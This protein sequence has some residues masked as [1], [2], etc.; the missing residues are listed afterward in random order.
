MKKLLAILTF[1]GCALLLQAQ[2]VKPFIKAGQEFFETG[3]YNE[4]VDQF[5]KAIDLQP[6][7]ADH[8]V[9]RARAYERLD[10]KLK[11]AEDYD[12]AITFDVKEED[13]YNSAAKLYFQLQEYPKT[14]ERCKASLDLSMDYEILAIKVDALLKNKNYSEALLDAKLL[15]LKKS[16]D[17]NNYR[18]GIASEAS[19]FDVDA[20]KAYQSAIDKNKRFYEAYTSLANLQ[21]KTKNSI[22]ALANV[23]EA[24]KINPKYAEAYR[25]R[26]QIY[27]EQLKMAEVINDISTVILLEPEVDENYFQRGLYYQQFAQH[28]NAINDFSKVIALSPTRADAYF[29]R[30]TSY[31]QINSY[32]E[33]IKDYETL[34]K[35]DTKDPNIEDLLA[36]SQI[37]L[38]EL[39][40]EEDKPII[41]IVSPLSKGDLT[42]NVPKNAISIEVKG[43]V[44]EKSEIKEFTINGEKVNVEKIEE[45]YGFSTN[46]TLQRDTFTLTISDVY[47]NALSKE[48]AILRTE[49]D[50]PDIKLMAP[51]AS[52]NLTIFLD[53]QDPKVYIEGKI[54]DESLISSI[55]IDDMLA[56]YSPQELNPTFQAYLNVTNKD[57]FTIK[58]VDKYGNLST[59]T[60]TLNREGAT[61]AASNPMGKTWAIFIE[62]SNYSNFANLEGP[63]K[64]VSLM[65]S[66]LVKYN[67]NNLIHKKDMSK[68][69]MERFFS[70]ELRDLVRSNNVKSLLIWYAGHG[71]FLNQTGYW[72]AVDSKRDDEFTYF[73]IS[74]LKSALNTYTSSIDHTL[75][76]T[77]ACESGPSFYQAMRSELKPRSCGD[78]SAKMKSSQV[79]SS[80]GYEL[81]VDNSQFTKTFANTLIN[82][83]DACLPIES[84]VQRVTTAV[85]SNNQQKP[86][87]G[88]IA[89]L[90]DEDGTF[91]FIAK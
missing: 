40:R 53:S 86:L 91:F 4:A 61:I 81:A 22:S 26:A 79:F 60:Y 39:N 13:W 46:L 62:N 65:K 50:T 18:F 15:V 58:V 25:V 1:F 56:S 74:S 72:V 77:D 52:D 84:I 38:F 20:L 85:Q 21:F 54:F 88:K 47:N 43:T 6:A 32:K 27:G 49:I 28:P 76:I 23:N 35:L 17:Q 11:A 36:K 82:S 70:I 69:E 66:A 83:Q 67:V 37:R 45:G 5:T 55:Y 87:F 73:N 33:A 44:K 71:K 10:E 51:Y 12:N 7:N 48:Y 2:N 89:G 68:E 75:V 9:K 80:A 64:D 16:T 19:G 59:N 63:T 31:E 42:L 78:L 41:T 8:Y 90:G 30:A 14:I 3:K 24:I 29:K 57:R 34:K